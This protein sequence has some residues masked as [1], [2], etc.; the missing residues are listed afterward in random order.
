MGKEYR[1]R[2]RYVQVERLEI[3]DTFITNSRVITRSDVEG[4]AATTGYTLPLFM[5]DE[6]A[7]EAGW[8]SQLVPGMLGVS[9]CIGLLIQSGFLA[10]VIASMGTDGLSFNKPI[11]LYD[12]IHVEVEVTGKKQTKKG[13]WICA[14]KWVAKNQRGENVTEGMNR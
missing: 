4:F 10:T 11:Y 12:S 13:D 8:E 14:Y 6:A 9:M 3:G 7:R 1:E 2:D 5:S